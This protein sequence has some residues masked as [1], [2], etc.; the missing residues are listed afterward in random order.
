[1]DIAV[2]SNAYFCF[3][4]GFFSKFVENRQSL[5]KESSAKMPVRRSGLVRYMK[6]QEKSDPLKTVSVFCDRV[7]RFKAQPLAMEPR[8]FGISFKWEQII[9]EVKGIFLLTRYLS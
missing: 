5:R 1:M 7:S 2:T 9:H 4:G 6:Q 3:L 8:L